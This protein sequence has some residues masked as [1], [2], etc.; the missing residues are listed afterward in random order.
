[1]HMTKSMETIS[2]GTLNSEL[3]E[4]AERL[5]TENSLALILILGGKK[6]IKKVV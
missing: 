2:D 1:M 5:D 6:A 4:I 3:A